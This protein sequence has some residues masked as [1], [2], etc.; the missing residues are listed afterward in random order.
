[1]RTNTERLRNSGKKFVERHDQG[2]GMFLIAAVAASR[3]SAKSKGEAMSTRYVSAPNDIAY[4]PRR[5]IL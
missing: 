1:M 3:S 2:Q 5:A 4:A